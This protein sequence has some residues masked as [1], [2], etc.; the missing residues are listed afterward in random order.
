MGKRKIIWL[1][2]FIIAAALSFAI[3]RYK[4]NS[5][6]V[7]EINYARKMLADAELINSASFANKSYKMA[8]AYYDSAMFTWSAENQR[9][10]L[11]RNYEIP[12]N[13]AINSSN[14]LKTAISESKKN[15]IDIEESLNSRK[16]ELTIKI[17]TFEALYGNFPLTKEERNNYINCNMAFKEGSLA[18]ENKNYANSLAKFDFVEPVIENLSKSY[19]EKLVKYFEDYSN[20]SSQVRESINNSRKNR[21]YCVI[22]DKIA[23]K[24]FLYYNGE[25]YKSFE[26]ELSTNW[27]G[28]KNQQ[29]DKS[30][31]EGI[32]KILEKKSNGKTKYYKALLLDYPNEEDKSRFQLN[33]ISGL[34]GPNPK[35]GGHIEIHGDGGKGSDWTDGCI[36]LEN[37]NMDILFKYCEVGTTVAIVGSTVPLDDLI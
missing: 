21:N 12:R 32:Y 35:I 18:L 30:T 27:V 20:W 26:I 6:P 37:N 23:R 25:L 33:K 15:L 34:L 11:F 19:E 22:I 1:L 28:D 31:P 29:G 9:F 2:L 3:I 13:F 7:D 24:C 16:K 36:A 8:K 4:T 17:E 14:L 5:P 10:I